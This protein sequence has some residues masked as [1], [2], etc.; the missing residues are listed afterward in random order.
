MFDSIQYYACSY[1]CPYPH[2]REVKGPSLARN[3]LPSARK[4]RWNS[5]LQH[6]ETGV[7]YV[8]TMWPRSGLITL[9]MQGPAPFRKGITLHTKQSLPENPDL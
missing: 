2:Q 6:G 3:Q 9:G 1:T 7:C 8:R 4:P 5:A